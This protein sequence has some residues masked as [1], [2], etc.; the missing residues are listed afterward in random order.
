MDITFHM[1]LILHDIGLVSGSGYQTIKRGGSKTVR[2]L[3]NW[4]VSGLN[5]C[6]RLSA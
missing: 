2:N 6:T 3:G 1:F 4:N 5:T